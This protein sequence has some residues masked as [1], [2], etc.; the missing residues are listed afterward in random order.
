MG[1]WF[2]GRVTAVGKAAE[3][4][5]ELTLDVAGTPLPAAHAHAGQY[6]KAALEGVG[7]GFFAIASAP[8][9]GDRI[10]LLV[11][12]GTK[13]G[14]ALAELPPGA[15]LRLSGPL[16]KGFPLERARGKD[17]LLFATGSGLAA[18]RPVVRVL[19]RNRASYGQVTLFVG[20][21]TPSSFAYSRE[22]DEWEAAGVRVLRTVSR[23]GPSGWEGLTGYVQAHLGELK[24][25]HAVAFA[26]GQEEM[27]KGVTRALEARGLPPGSVFRNH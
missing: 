24:V 15:R 4:L 20:V 9:E 6:L 13:L 22:L 2:E 26:V 16:G 17:V 19:L 14:A 10:E 18:I 23:P 8:G 5:V 11:K 1:D 7:E 3:G 27:V 25:T 12:T 21:R